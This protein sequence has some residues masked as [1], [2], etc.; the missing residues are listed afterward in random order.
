[1]LRWLVFFLVLACPSRSPGGLCGARPMPL[2]LFVLVLRPPPSVSA[3][4]GGEA[5][6][7]LPLSFLHHLLSRS[8]AP[9]ALL[10]A[11]RQAASV[12][13][14]GAG[15]EGSRRAGPCTPPAGPG[16][17]RESG[18]GTRAI[19][20]SSTCARRGAQTE[21]AERAP[22]GAARDGAQEE[23]EE[24]GSR[25]RNAMRAS[26]WKPR[27]TKGSLFLHRLLQNHKFKLS[28][29]IGSL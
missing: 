23:E 11:A 3:G 2:L 13:G 7:R 17:P 24:E 14:A 21:Q 20:A 12:A 25:T 18:D 9:P 22:L 27:Q 29:W 28:P 26:S 19:E 6:P 16:R 4:G 15:A 1:M 10:P 5:W 8:C